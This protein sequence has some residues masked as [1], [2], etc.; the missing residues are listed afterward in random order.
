MC[1]QIK[2][3]AHELQALYKYHIY[4]YNVFYY[5]ITPESGYD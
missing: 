2:S 1:L 4:V 5:H 3:N